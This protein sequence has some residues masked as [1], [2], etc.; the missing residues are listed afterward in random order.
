MHGEKLNG[1]LSY[2][3]SN[4]TAWCTHSRWQSA[5]AA[6]CLSEAYIQEKMTSVQSFGKKFAQI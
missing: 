2:A 6:T 4:M 5:A 1:Y 3:A